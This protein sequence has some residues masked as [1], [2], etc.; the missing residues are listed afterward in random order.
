MHNMEN[1]NNYI[2]SQF[3]EAVDE[4]KE[5]LKIPSIS[6]DSKYEK[7][8]RRGAE[9]LENQ[10]KKLKVKTKIYETEGHPIVYGEYIVSDDAPTRSEERRVGKECTAQRGAG[11]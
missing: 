5:F 4:L 2:D 10:L 1:L 6:A 9:W 7:E 11:K 3:T 8:V